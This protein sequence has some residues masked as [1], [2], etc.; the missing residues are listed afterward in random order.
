MLHTLIVKNEIYQI[1]HYMIHCIQIFTITFEV[2]RIKRDKGKTIK[3]IH[4]I[5][6][7]KRYGPSFEQTLI[8]FS[9]G[10]FVSRLVKIS[11]FILEKKILKL[12]RYIFAISLSSPFGKGTS[13][14]F[15]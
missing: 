11:L 4:T 12:Y 15:E 3:H 14:L 13:P 8:S 6:P 1:G 5:S 9:E 10:C 2:K 7:W